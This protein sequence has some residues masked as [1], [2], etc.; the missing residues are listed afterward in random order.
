MDMEKTLNAVGK[1]IFVK[2]YFV[3]ANMSN[4]DCLEI[5]TENFTEKSKR[6]RVSHAKEIFREGKQFDALKIVCNSP[7]IDPDTKKKAETILFKLNR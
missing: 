4:E 1:V 5:F 7:N 6:S 2:Y 3:L